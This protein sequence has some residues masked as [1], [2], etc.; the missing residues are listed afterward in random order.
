MKLVSIIFY[1]EPHL[2]STKIRKGERRIKYRNSFQIFFIP[3]RILSSVEENIQRQ[4][5]LIFRKVICYFKL[6]T[7]FV[8]TIGFIT[9][10]KFVE[11][12]S[13]DDE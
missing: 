3:N 10:C 8:A 5:N 6:I 13:S 12:L 1:P 11:Y 4:K 9:C 2:S 7:I